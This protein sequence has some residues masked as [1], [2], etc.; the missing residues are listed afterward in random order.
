MGKDSGILKISGNTSYGIITPE[1]DEFFGKNHLALRIWIHAIMSTPGTRFYKNDIQEKFGIGDFSWRAA[2]A[3]LKNAGLMEILTIKDCHGKIFKKE[4]LFRTWDAKRSIDFEKEKAEKLSGDSGSFGCV[5][6]FYN[7][8]NTN[9][10]SLVFPSM[11]KPTHIVPE[12]ESM[13]ERDARPTET[14]L[15]EDEMNP[16]M[17]RKHRDRFLA[18]FAGIKTFQT[19]DDSPA[20]RGQLAKVLHGNVAQQ[21]ERLNLAGAGVFLTVNE[22]DGKGRK[23]ENITKVR[24]IFVDLDGASPETMLGACP[25]LVVE[26]SPDRYHGYWFVKDFP[27]EGFTQMQKTLAEMFNGDIAVNDLPRVMRVPGYSHKK[28]EPFV[29]RIVLDMGDIEPLTYAEAVEKF[30]PK[31]VKKWSA[32]KHQK[33]VDENGEYAGPYGSS[34]GARNNGL[35]RFVGG[36]VKRHKDR[37]HIEA[38]AFKWGMSC[39]PPMDSREIMGVVNSVSRYQR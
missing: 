1:I 25:H 20:K 2:T 39:S 22:T 34:N 12:R 32:P 7:K 28:S 29:S 19:F 33:H 35:A 24:A 3:F 11:G 17:A 26:S 23:R 8:I 9:S 6:D 4:I 36:M 15:I 38:E 10:I 16:E 21:L 13:R 14:D 37:D 18:K 5:Y 27:L 30:P 31:P